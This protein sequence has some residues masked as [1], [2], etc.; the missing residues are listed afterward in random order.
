[1]IRIVG[2]KEFKLLT[3]EEKNKVIN[4]TSSSKNW[5]R[6]LSP[7]FLGPVH[8]YQGR[9]AKNVENA[10]QYSKVYKEHVGALGLPTED[11]LSWAEGGWSN[12]YAVRYPMGKGAK[13]LY[14]FWDGVQYNYIEARKR[15]YIPLYRKAVLKS[16]AYS[17]LE[18][19]YH[20]KD[21]DIILFDF[22]G[23][24]HL[25]KNMTYQEVIN[26]ES[27]KMGHAFVLAMLLDEYI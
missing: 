23:Y 9:H 7:F 24:D 6:G 22:D 20:N 13:P 21:K 10:W 3:K 17:K 2:P 14:A 12:S 19:E 1:M 8:L 11:W 16:D 18:R 25:T 5:S 15:I 4:T 26:C 27:L